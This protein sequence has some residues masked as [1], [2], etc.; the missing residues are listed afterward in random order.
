[1]L[2]TQRT[3]RLIVHSGVIGKKRTGASG[4]DG[5]VTGSFSRRDARGRKRKSV[6]FYLV[7]LLSPVRQIPL[8]GPWMTLLAESTA[9]SVLLRYRGR[10]ICRY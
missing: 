2:T 3:V 6:S 1:M 5:V 7:L 10:L 4:D 9:F 8:P